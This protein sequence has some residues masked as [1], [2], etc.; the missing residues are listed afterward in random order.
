MKNTLTLLRNS[1]V[2]TT[3]IPTIASSITGLP[4]EIHQVLVGQ[5]LADAHADRSS[6]TSN[7]R[8]SWSFGAKYEEYAGFIASIFSA[9]FFFLAP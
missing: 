8:I 1:T 3:A 6:L 2:L 9:Y 5:L 7:T 4:S